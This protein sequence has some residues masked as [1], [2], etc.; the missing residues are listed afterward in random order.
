MATLRSICECTR[1][2][3][4]LV[5]RRVH[6][7]QLRNGSD[8]L[9]ESFHFLHFSRRPN[10]KLEG[11]NNDRLPKNESADIATQ[12]ASSVSIILLS[13]S[14]RSFV[15]FESTVTTTD[16]LPNLKSPFT[17]THP[18]TAIQQWTRKRLSKIPRTSKTKLFAKLVKIVC[19]VRI[20]LPDKSQ[21]LPHL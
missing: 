19:A 20:P 12:Q 21:Y 9:C 10:A 4:P 18:L 6:H 13:G 8:K 3:H 5:R 7:N 2:T 15:S 17:R 14:S 1:I 11:K 16:S